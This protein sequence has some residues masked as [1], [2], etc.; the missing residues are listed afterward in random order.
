[1]IPDIAMLMIDMF[2]KP[3]GAEIIWFAGRIQGVTHDLCPQLLQ[4]D[5]E[6]G[7][8][9]ARMAGNKNSLSLINVLEHDFLSSSVSKGDTAEMGYKDP[10]RVSH[11]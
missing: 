6:P 4:P 5:T 8:L 10:M 1:M 7:T 2:R 11:L 3:A 9:E